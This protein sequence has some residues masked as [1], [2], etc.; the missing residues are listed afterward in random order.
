MRYCK[1]G[2]FVAKMGCGD[3]FRISVEPY[4]GWV[5]CAGT[6]HKN[7]VLAKDFVWQPRIPGAK[8]EYYDEE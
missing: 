4:D 5:S 3:N 8:P 2:S 7:W 6:D 1:N